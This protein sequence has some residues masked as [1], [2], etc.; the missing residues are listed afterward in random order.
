MSSLVILGSAGFLGRAFIESQSSR[1][2]LKVVSRTPLTNLA[3]GISTFLR[4][5][6]SPTSLDTV[7]EPDDI[8]LNLAY[9]PNSG[10][11]ENSALMQNV[12]A[13]C[14]RKKVKRLV[15]C[16][17]AVVVGVGA[18]GHIDEETPCSP[19][20]H[21]EEIKLKLEKQVFG[22]VSQGLDVA[23]LRPT[24][25]VGPGG[26]NLAKLAESLK[27]KNRF[28]NY[29]K[30]CLFGRRPMHLVPVRNV[31]FALLHLALLPEKQN[32]SIYIVASDKDKDNY[33]WRVDSILRQAL[34]IPQETWPIF[35]LPLGILS[36]LLKLAGRSDPTLH[37]VFDSQKLLATGFKLADSVAIA[38][39]E[40]GLVVR[41][42]D[43]ESQS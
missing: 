15:H 22:A 20:S 43:Q 6:T 18:T 38:V 3:P 36:L 12:I 33:F 27:S 17:T 8:V 19:H 14:L 31:V 9:M 29:G 28:V 7:L 1:F 11:A 35:T 4:D 30:L 34:D 26:K 25:I 16:S 32:G 42:L 10:E 24:A 37:Q 2:P 23:I 21:Y 39:H 5:L 41:S 40:F 13:A